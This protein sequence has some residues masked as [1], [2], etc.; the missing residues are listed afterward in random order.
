MLKYQ[1]PLLSL[2]TPPSLSLYPPPSHEHLSQG[3]HTVFIPGHTHYNTQ[4]DGHIPV[5]L[6]WFDIIFSGIKLLLIIFY[7]IY[8]LIA[9]FKFRLFFR[10]YHT[11]R[12]GSIIYANLARS[13]RF[14][15]SAHITHSFMTKMAMSLTQEFSVPGFMKL[16][17]FW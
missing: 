1:F 17:K 10:K 9:Q 14:C 13:R 8:L 12:R 6:P 2:F 4:T 11:A 16:H 15:S 5:L 7:L 3:T